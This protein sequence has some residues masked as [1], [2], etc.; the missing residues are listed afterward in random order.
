[1]A[2]ASRD[3]QGIAQTY[4]RGQDAVDPFFT[5]AALDLLGGPSIAGL[6]GMGIPGLSSSATSTATGT[7]S[8][9]VGTHFV[10]SSP[11]ILG[12]DNKASGT[13]STGGTTG[14]PASTEATGGGSGSSYPG[15][16]SGKSLMDML[17]PA[18]TIVTLI[19]GVI[20][21]MKAMK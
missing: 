18:A 3:L 17:G 13:V 7:F 1:M 4:Q 8:N 12:N 5:N 11:F 9:T 2:D 21:L 19:V 14:G 20:A 6:G 16:Q 10:Q 15:A